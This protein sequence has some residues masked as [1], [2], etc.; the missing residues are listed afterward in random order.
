MLSIIW[1]TR[2]PRTRRIIIPVQP[3][4]IKRENRAAG[5]AIRGILIYARA[6]QRR[7]EGDRLLN[8]EFKIDRVGAGIQ[9]LESDM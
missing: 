1:L 2:A 7:R 8:V 3:P 4:G 5:L 9:H 6:V